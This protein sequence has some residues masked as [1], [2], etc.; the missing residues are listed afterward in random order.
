M[1]KLLASLL[2]SIV[3]PFTP[4]VASDHVL[5]MGDSLAMGMAPYIGD[6]HATVLGA[7]TYYQWDVFL[8]DI[9]KDTTVVVI[10][11]ANDSDWSEARYNKRL[12]DLLTTISQKSRAVFLVGPPCST[13]PMIDGRLKVINN[14][15]HKII[16]KLNDDGITNIHFISMRALTTIGL[17]EQDNNCRPFYRTRDGVHFTRDG[18]AYMSSLIKMKIRNFDTSF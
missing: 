2:L 15:Q 8:D 12:T 10:L 4:A 3:L 5:L 1:K 17:N 7:S 18:Y 13:I 9:T 11:G 16:D 14:L 6:A